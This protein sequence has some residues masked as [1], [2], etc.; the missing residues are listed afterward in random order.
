MMLLDPE[1]TLSNKYYGRLFTPIT[2]FFALFMTGIGH[3]FELKN[4][5]QTV[6]ARTAN[7][8]ALD[9]WKDIDVEL[10]KHS[11]NIVV[12][13][14]AFGILF[15]ALGAYFLLLIWTMPE[16]YDQFAKFLRCLKPYKPKEGN[17]LVK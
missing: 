16:D 4:Y 1:L 9:S 13:Y 8:L 6:K 2:L 10:Q 12:K 3:R 14:G 7:V 15:G 17:I 11:G 5:I